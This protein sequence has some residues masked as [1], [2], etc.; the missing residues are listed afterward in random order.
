MLLYDVV[1]RGLTP[2]TLSPIDPRSK[3]SLEI[4]VFENTH[5]NDGHFLVR[6]RYSLFP[7]LHRLL[8]FNLFWNFQ[9][10]ANLQPND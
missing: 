9:I 4:E 5:A 10:S 6:F 3:R 2:L 7:S 1:F 8:F